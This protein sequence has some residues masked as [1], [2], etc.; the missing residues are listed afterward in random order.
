MSA[1]PIACSI[2]L[3]APGK[4]IG[5]LRLSWSDNERAYGVIPVPI[6]VIK[7]GDGPTA[8]VTSG[9]H[10]DEYEGLLIAR[11]LIAD[12]QPKDLA[13]R[14]IVMP[15]V[16]WPAVEARTRTSPIDLQNMNRAFPGEV[17]GGPTAMIADFIERVLLPQVN[18]AAD[19][20]SGGTKSIYTPCGYVYGMGDRGFRERKLAAA[21]AF[22]APATAVV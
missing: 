21:H 11:R 1:P 6:A 13:G 16:N 5:H 8:L 9:V 12:M 19:L 17:R 4:R 7:G 2:D 18:V 22:G 14:L 20:H 10:G 15:G 3:T